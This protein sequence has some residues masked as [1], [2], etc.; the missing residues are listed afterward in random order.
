PLFMV[1]MLDYLEQQDFLRASDQAAAGGV[2]ER[3]LDE[4]GPQRLRQLLD[5]H[6]ER[7][8]AAEQQGLEGGRGAG[9]EVGVASVAAGVQT[10]T[11]VIEAVCERLA[12]QGQFLE[13]RG[14][15]AWPDGTVSGRYGFR[16]ALY[17]EVVYQRLSSGR[18]VRYHRLIG[19][20]EEAGYGAQAS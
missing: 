7:L 10:T 1:Q 9:G 2:A 20:R 3:R 13:D 16:H 19:S 12:R 5:A 18:R 11:D 4:A 14:L 17:Q 6:V 8:T 15:A